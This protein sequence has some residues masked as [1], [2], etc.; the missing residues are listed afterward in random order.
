MGIIFPIE[1]DRW[2]VTLQGVGGD[3]PPTSDDGSSSSPARCGAAMQRVIAR[4]GRAAWMIA[5]GDDLR[6][7]TTKGAKANIAVRM[8]HR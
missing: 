6:R 1:N 7:P 3:D 8:Q 2:I 4:G 5:T